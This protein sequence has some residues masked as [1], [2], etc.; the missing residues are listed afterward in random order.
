[1]LF[2]VERRVEIRG[3]AWWALWGGGESEAESGGS[4]EHALEVSPRT[5]AVSQF[6]SPDQ[7]DSSSSSSSGFS[8]EH[9][10]RSNSFM[11]PVISPWIHVDALPVC[12]TRY[13]YRKV[14]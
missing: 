6:K 7:S 1:M 11:H 5:W 4:W 9:I 2:I 8:G 13:V 12:F 3:S 10:S 14:V